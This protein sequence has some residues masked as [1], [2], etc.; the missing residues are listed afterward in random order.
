[1]HS[2][3]HPQNQK[4]RPGSSPS[5][6][7]QGQDHQEFKANLDYVTRPHLKQAQQK[8]IFKK[9]QTWVSSS[10]S[11][12][13]RMFSNIIV[14]K[15]C[16]FTFSLTIYFKSVCFSVKGVDIWKIHFP[17]WQCPVV[18]TLFDDWEYPFSSACLYSRTQVTGVFLLV[19]F[20][21]FCFISLILLGHSFNS[22]LSSTF[23]VGLCVGSLE[24][25]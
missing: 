8:T 13:C 21:A 11:R 23:T 24:S 14:Y 5:T 19:S 10:N 9:I 12:S 18:P 2:V 4:A 15:F 25:G 17:P 7:R 22:S 16:S 1:M 6:E 3:L 20:W